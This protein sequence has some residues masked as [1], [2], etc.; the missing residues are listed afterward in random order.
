MTLSYVFCQ[1]LQIYHFIQF[2]KLKKSGFWSIEN[3]VVDHITVIYLYI[4]I[5]ICS[6]HIKYVCLM[7]LLMANKEIMNR[8]HINMHRHH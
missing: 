2:C 5:D 7:P 3:I 6:W 4:F 8:G 1:F